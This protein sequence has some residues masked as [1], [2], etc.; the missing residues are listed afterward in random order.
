MYAEFLS[1]SFKSPASVKS[2]ISGVRLLHKFLDLPCHAAESFELTLTLRG[3]DLSS[4]HRT[5]KKLPITVAILHNICSNL[6][7]HIVDKVFRAIVLVAFFS[8]LRRSN[9]TPDSSSQ[10]DK[11]R[12]LCRGDIFVVEDGLRL[13]IKW[14]K[15]NQARERTPLIPLQAMPGHPL[16]PKQ[17]FLDMVAAVPASDNS[18]L[19]AIPGKKPGQILP[20]TTTQLSVKFK[21]VIASLG[22]DPA[23][24]SIHSFRRGGATLAFECGLDP[25]LIKSQGDWKSD[26]YL[27][28]IDLSVEHRLTL[29]KT[30]AHTVASQSADS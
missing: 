1:R 9:L 30:L 10:F 28:Y 24:Y 2:Y 20:F 21:A 25:L 16:C 26:A 4:D 6:G 5:S 3:L 8:F 7:E 15:T 22:L 23:R 19:F 18:P 12:H 14:S 29:S 13:L 17:A 11:K 27:E